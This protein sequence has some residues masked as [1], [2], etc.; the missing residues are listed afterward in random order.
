MS[1]LGDGASNGLWHIKVPQ[2]NDESPRRLCELLHR[3]RRGP[4]A[5][6]E[7]HEFNLLLMSATTVQFSRQKWPAS[8]PRYRL[9]PADAAQEVLI[10]L[11]E[12]ARTGFN[13]ADPEPG[14]VT[15]NDWLPM[16]S[17]VNIAIYR[18]VLTQ[19]EKSRK[20]SNRSVTAADYYGGG[21]ADRQAGM[22]ANES[23]SASPSAAWLDRVLGDA[24][25]A[26]IGDLILPFAEVDRL[27]RLVRAVCDQV[28]KH[29]SPQPYASLPAELREVPRELHGLVVSRVLRLVRESVA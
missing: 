28:R 11:R 17:V 26:A 24:E 18:L 10:H 1:V 14:G 4:L 8:L 2:W 15:A 29:Q 19:I 23:P 16:M 3:F 12:K 25:D 27:E 20:E 6:A 9:D 21:G 13:L 5:R 22:E 7:D